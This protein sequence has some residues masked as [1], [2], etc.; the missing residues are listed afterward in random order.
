MNI[1]RKLATAAGIAATAAVTFGLAA[2]T[3]A[4]STGKTNAEWDGNCSVVVASSTKD[5]SN[6]VYMIDGAEH[7]IEFADGTNTLQLPG[8][9]TDLWIKAGNNKSGQGS[10]YGEHYARPDRCDGP[11]PTT[12]Q[13]AETGTEVAM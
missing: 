1:S 6:V 12:G 9:I 5:I 11:S 3:S 8:E 4:A 10:G 2:P 13:T 7:R